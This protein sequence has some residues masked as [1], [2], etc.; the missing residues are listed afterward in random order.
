MG[1]RLHDHLND[2]ASPAAP[3]EVFD[4]PSRYPEH[5]PRLGPS[6]DFKGLCPLQGGNLYSGSQGCLGKGDRNLAV[7]I[8]V[9]SLKKLVGFHVDD[10]VEIPRWPPPDARFSLA[11]NPQF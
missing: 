8:V 4:P 9:L 7:D 11:L 1:G 5:F 2:L 3:S 10:H 6:W